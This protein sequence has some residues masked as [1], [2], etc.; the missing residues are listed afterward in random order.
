MLKLTLFI[1][2]F[3]T[4]TTVLFAQS[5]VLTGTLKDAETKSPLVGATVKLVSPTDS[6]TV[7]TNNRG[8]FEFRN[9]LPGTTYTL[10]ATY[11]GY[12]LLNKQ[13][14]YSDTL[15]P[16]GDIALNKEAKELTGVTVIGN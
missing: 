7:L 6:T 3:L 10:S 9:L 11:S 4:G 15:Q 5:P 13:I 14:V 16:L 8:V 1:T 12:E 2:I